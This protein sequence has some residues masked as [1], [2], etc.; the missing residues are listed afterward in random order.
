[1]VGDYPCGRYYRLSDVVV[2]KGQKLRKAGD[3][4][5]YFFINKNL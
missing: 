1:V 4:P 3:F 2:I 5:L